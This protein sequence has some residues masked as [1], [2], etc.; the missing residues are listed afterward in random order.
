VGSDGVVVAA[1]SRGVSG[2]VRNAKGD[3]TVTFSRDVS[4]CA[5]LAAAGNTNSQTVLASSNQVAVM[6]LGRSSNKAEDDSFT[7]IVS[8]PPAN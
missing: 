4:T 2:A 6:T 7:M 1:R 5:W 8:C 3:Y